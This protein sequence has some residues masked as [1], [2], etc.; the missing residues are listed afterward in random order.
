MIRRW[1]ATFPCSMSSLIMVTPRECESSGGE[2]PKEIDEVGGG[3]S[4]E[5]D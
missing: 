5:D 2:G 1:R 3:G 4:V